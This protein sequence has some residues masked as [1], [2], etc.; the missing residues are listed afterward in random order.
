VTLHAATRAEAKTPSPAHARAIVEALE[1]KGYIPVQIGLPHEQ[2][3]C[4]ERFT[5]TF[6]ESV[7]FVLSCGAL[8]TVD[9]AMAWIASGYKFPTI[10]LYTPSYYPNASSSTNWQPR[11]D[12]LIALEAGRIDEISV[13]SVISAI[14]SL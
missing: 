3:Y 9:S 6:F 2:Q 5:G 11:N 1:G 10:G 8:L 7:K 13:D 4:Q 12:N 14:S